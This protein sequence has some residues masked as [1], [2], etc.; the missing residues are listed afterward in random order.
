[1]ATLFHSPTTLQI[2]FAAAS[3]SETIIFQHFPLVG[4]PGNM[5]P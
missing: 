3:V 2:C 1:M 4:S 5:D